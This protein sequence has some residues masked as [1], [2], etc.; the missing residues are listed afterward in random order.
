MSGA[1]KL[2]GTK[3]LVYYKASQQGAT[4]HHAA[5]HARCV[6]LVSLMGLDDSMVIHYSRV[7]RA[8]YIEEVKGPAVV[9]WKPGTEGRQMIL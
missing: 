8:E 6:Q 7:W 1:L 4:R 9:V 2:P 3:E 5:E